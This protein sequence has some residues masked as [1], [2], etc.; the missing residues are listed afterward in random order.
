MPQQTISMGGRRQFVCIFGCGG[1]GIGAG[2]EQVNS[3]ERKVVEDGAAQPQAEALRSFRVQ[4]KILIQMKGSN[5]RPVDARHE[6][7]AES[8]SYWLGGRGKYHA[9]ALLILQTAGVVHRRY[10]RLL[11]A[12]CPRAI[13]R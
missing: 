6:M 2:L 8:I 5:T 1:F 12:P 13:W 9:N 4:A 3:S 10:L 7:S 11:F